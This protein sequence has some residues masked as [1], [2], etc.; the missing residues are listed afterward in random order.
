VLKNDQI[1]CALLIFIYHRA[2]TLT[3]VFYKT[4]SVQ[5]NRIFNFSENLKK[6][7]TP[8]RKIPIFRENYRSSMKSIHV[9][10]F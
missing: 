10:F 3:F 7:L 6:I 8:E 1:N 5:E 2:L 4:R 9:F